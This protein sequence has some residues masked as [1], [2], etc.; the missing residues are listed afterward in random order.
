[1]TTRRST[2]ELFH[3]TEEADEIGLKELG[4]LARRCDDPIQQCAVL[5]E[6]IAS[7][8]NG[9]AEKVDAHREYA[10]VRKASGNTLSAMGHRCIAF[11]HEKVPGKYWSL[12]DFKSPRADELPS[13]NQIEHHPHH[14]F[15]R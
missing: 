7:A 13:S 5:R 10:E 1:M 12:I 6:V 14:Q 3:F 15:A 11:V 4:R 9:S 8:S 2:P